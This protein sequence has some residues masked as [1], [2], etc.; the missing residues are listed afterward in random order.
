MPVLI[1]PELS[2][3]S[4]QVEGYTTHPTAGLGDTFGPGVNQQV[5]ITHTSLHIPSNK[6]PLAHTFCP[7]F[8]KTSLTPFQ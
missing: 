4:G 2:T 3:V 1:Y 8:S 6:T 5:T 7:T